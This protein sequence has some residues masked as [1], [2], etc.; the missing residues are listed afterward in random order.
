MS[1]SA[2]KEKKGKVHFMTILEVV[3]FNFFPAYM[4]FLPTFTAFIKTSLFT[5]S[6]SEFQYRIHFTSPKESVLFSVNLTVQNM[7]KIETTQLNIC[8]RSKT[9]TFG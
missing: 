8:V 2:K 1:R 9:T 5:L 6:R 7:L 4:E 3:E